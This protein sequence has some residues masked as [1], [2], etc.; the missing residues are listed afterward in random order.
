MT[1]TRTFI[2]VPRPSIT[3]ADIDRWLA[4][5]VLHATGTKVEKKEVQKAA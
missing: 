5:G 3:E 2:P 1:Q 4:G